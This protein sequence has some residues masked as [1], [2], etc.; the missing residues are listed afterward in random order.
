MAPQ[1]SWA[2]SPPHMGV[3]PWA[4]SLAP[5]QAAKELLGCSGCRLECQHR[6]GLHPTHAAGVPAEPVLQTAQAGGRAWSQALP[7]FRT[8][9]QRRALGQGFLG[10]CL[11]GLLADHVWQ[12]LRGIIL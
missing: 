8:Q 1:L 9:K 7:T 3:L 6:Q 10:V 11:E 5:E 4:A 2:H 12:H